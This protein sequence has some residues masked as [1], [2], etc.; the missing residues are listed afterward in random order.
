MKWFS[1]VVTCLLTVALLSG[2]LGCSKG[3]K[4]TVEGEGGR[5]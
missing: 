3:E 4:K 5:S 1:L 2:G